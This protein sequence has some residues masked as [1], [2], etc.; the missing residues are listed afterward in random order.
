MPDIRHQIVYT[1]A[2]LKCVVCPCFCVCFHR[3]NIEFSG[4]IKACVEAE[5]KIL[6]SIREAYQQWERLA[7]GQLVCKA[8]PKI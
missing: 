4:Y 3:L 6:E 7:V 2:S 5:I 8:T 1:C